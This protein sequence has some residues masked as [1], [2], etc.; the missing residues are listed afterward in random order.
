MNVNCHVGGFGLFNTPGTRGIGKGAN[1][2]RGDEGKDGNG[3]RARG[4]NP[5]RSLGLHLSFD[6]HGR[7]TVIHSVTAVA[8][9]TDDNGGTLGLDFATSCALDGVL[10]VDF[11]CSHR[12]GAPLL[13]DDDCPAAARSFNLDVGFSLAE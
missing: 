11:C 9:D 4:C 1:T 6:F 12:A 3:G 2:R 13:S 8:D 10:A 7:T 5:G